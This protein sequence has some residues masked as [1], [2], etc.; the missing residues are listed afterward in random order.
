MVG[1]SI[2]K[3]IMFD[4]LCV[5]HCGCVFFIARSFVVFVFRNCIF[6]WTVEWVA[7]MMANSRVGECGHETIC[8]RT[9][10][11]NTSQLNT[12][13]SHFIEVW[14][15][16]HRNRVNCFHFHGRLRNFRS[17]K[18]SF[19]DLLIKDKNRILLWNAITEL[20]FAKKK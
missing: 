9:K 16:Y 1:W 11:D 20:N 6:I 14:T 19:Q 15:V 8:Q 17:L 5:S 18:K 4:I 7:P 12:I 10:I 3:E 13:T 2:Q